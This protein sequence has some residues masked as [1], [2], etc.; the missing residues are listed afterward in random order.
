MSLAPDGLL[1]EV[2]AAKYGPGRQVP[3]SECTGET[4]VPNAI[5]KAAEKCH[6]FPSNTFVSKVS[7]LVQLAPKYQTVSTDVAHND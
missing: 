5:I 3:S 1:P 7:H 2:I 4:S 6:I